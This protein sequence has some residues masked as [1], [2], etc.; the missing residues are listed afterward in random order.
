MLSVQITY[1]RFFN[2]VNILNLSMKQN[3]LGALLLAAGFS[4][5]SLVAPAKANNY[6][7]WSIPV[8]NGRV[9]A[10]PA[11]GQV[12]SAALGAQLPAALGLSD[13]HQLR[14]ESDKLDKLGMQ[15]TAYQ[16]Y[17]LGVKVEDAK[18]LVHARDGWV[19]RVNGNVAPLGTLSVQPAI[20]AKEA[21]AIAGRYTGIT[22][23]LRN[24]AP[25][26]VIAGVAAGSG[27]K[28]YALAY[29]VRIDGRDADRK[30]TMVNVY[31]DAQQGKV[32]HQRSLMAHGDVNATANTYYSGQ[33]SIVTD[34]TADGYRLRDNGR[35]IETYQGGGVD[36]DSLGF[37]AEDRDYYHHTTNWD[38]FRTFSASTLQTAST[39]LM[40]G[41]GQSNGLLFAL[42]E[43]D[44]SV[45]SLDSLD[46]VIN[47]RFLFIFS[48]TALP[49]E[50]GGFYSIMNPGRRYTGAYLNLFF[51]TF[52]LQDTAHYAVL[53]TTI[54]VHPWSD[55]LGNT[56]TYEIARKKNPALDAHWGMEQTHDFYSQVMGR[57]SYDDAG[58]VVKNYVGA[59]DD[60]NASAAP[61]PYNF[62]MYGMGDGINM[63]PVVGLDVMGHEFTHMVTE[64]NGHGGLIYEGEPGALNESFSDIFG[65]SI[66]FFA[67]PQEANWTMGEGIILQAPGFFRSMSQ[68]KLAENPDTYEGEFWKDPSDLG[69]DN[70]G[71]HYNSGVQN[72]WFYLLA[73]GGSGTND[74]NDAY[75]VTGIGLA[76]AEQIAYRNLTTYLTP[77]SDY[78]DAYEGSLQATLDLFNND[79]ASQEYR[80]VKQAWYAV[81]IGGDATV[82]VKEVLI[83]RDDLKLYPNPATQRVTIASSVAQ[84]LEAQV[85]NVVG[86]PV[87]QLTISKGLNPVDISGLAKGIYMIRYNTG[88]RGYV[89]KL[90]VY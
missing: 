69:N 83:G 27:A 65:T 25:E 48:P 23:L 78:Y 39:T 73:E 54:G 57:N 67:K 52:T 71:V 11:A 85:L 76:K 86:V 72:K 26:L 41:V 35:K 58:S 42:A 21:A 44:P 55:G 40:D 37:F 16:Q 5:C 18:V 6:T 50:A 43:G 2:C 81:G 31:V 38:L 7:G 66:E 17:Y 24:Y 46:L 59:G 28:Q 14:L 84:P 45:S 47:P 75:N 51:P 13:K 82:P 90:T 32:L 3:G 1:F 87:M 4:L 89:Q 22:R 8:N 49:Y 61:D 53:D 79:T 15:H 77:A 63:D 10:N 20:T 12:K 33:R 70:G 68:P 88:S 62:M 64:H 30:L 56:G 80:S 29:K 19:T 74:K 60:L 34:S 9:A 36:A